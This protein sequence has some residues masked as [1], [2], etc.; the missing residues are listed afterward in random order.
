VSERIVS[1][2]EQTD[3]GGGGR[4]EALGGKDGGEVSVASRLGRAGGL[5][6]LELGRLVDNDP[7]GLLLLLSALG[8]GGGSLFESEGVDSSGSRRGEVGDGRVLD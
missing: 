8:C 2:L 6:G 1:D 3:N 4:D 7:D 5:L